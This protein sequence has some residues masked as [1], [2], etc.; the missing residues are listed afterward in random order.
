MTVVIIFI[1][2]T[3]YL[4]FSSRPSTNVSDT[5]LSGNTSLGGQTQ[6]EIST[7]LWEQSFEESF[8]SD[9]DV[10]FEGNINGYEEVQGEYGFIQ[11]EF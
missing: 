6:E 11:P 9:L 3:L 2:I 4:F 10:F 5:L 7:S 8:Y 1:A